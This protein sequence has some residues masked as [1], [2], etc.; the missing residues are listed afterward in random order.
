[1]CIWECGART[2]QRW[3]R[4]SDRT[5]R[6]HSERLIWTQ[7]RQA[8]TGLRLEAGR[9][10]IS[11]GEVAENRLNGIEVSGTAAVTISGMR[12]IRNPNGAALIEIPLLRLPDSFQPT[13]SRN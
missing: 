1:M 9:T 4:H 8:T 13:L 3:V 7:T 6:T 2:R 11:Y 10:E 5:A 12:I